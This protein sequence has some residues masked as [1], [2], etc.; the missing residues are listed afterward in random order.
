MFVILYVNLSFF[1]HLEY[2]SEV[3]PK[4]YNDLKNDSSVRFPEKHMLNTLR[5]KECYQ[6]CFSKWS[7]QRVRQ[8]WDDFARASPE[9]AKV[10]SEVPNAIRGAMDFD[11]F[12]WAGSKFSQSDGLHRIPDCLALAIESILLEVIAT[13]QETSTNYVKN[14]TQEMVSMWNEHIEDM[15]SQVVKVITDNAAT[16]EESPLNDMLKYLKPC[17]LSKHPEAVKKHG[18]AFLYIF[19]FTFIYNAKFVLINP[20]PPRRSEVRSN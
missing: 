1:V 3:T 19:D 7:K 17:D 10:H 16:H 8:R 6:G 14:M 12:K 5:R 9:L 20:P 13:G 15:R 2:D 4:E 18:C 11:T